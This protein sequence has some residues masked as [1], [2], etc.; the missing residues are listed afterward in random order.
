MQ[1][2]SHFVGPRERPALVTLIQLPPLP[3]VGDTSVKCSMQSRVYA[4]EVFGRGMI[5]AD[6]AEAERWRER[7]QVRMAQTTTRRFPTVA[8]ARRWL[9]EEL[10]V[11]VVSSWHVAAGGAA[12]AGF[13]GGAMDE[14]EE[15]EELIIGP[16]A[17]NEEAAPSRIPGTR[18]RLSR[19]P[20]EIAALEAEQAGS[21]SGRAASSYSTPGHRLALVTCPDAAPV[22][23]VTVDLREGRLVASEAG[24]GPEASGGEPEMLA[25][26]TTEARPSLLGLRHDPLALETAEL[27]LTR[28]SRFPDFGFELVLP[29]NVLYA[30][31]KNLRVRPTL[32]QVTSV[33]GRQAAMLFEA[34]NS[35]LGSIA[36]ALRVT[37]LD[38]SVCLKQRVA[39]WRGRG[40][41]DAKGKAVTDFGVLDSLESLVRERG[42]TVRVTDVQHAARMARQQVIGGAGSGAGSGS[43]NT[44]A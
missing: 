14:E 30:S 32:Q 17:D 43:E 29:G 11:P 20:F 22:T 34:L 7:F 24:A 26:T 35:D 3:C 18:S 9:E 19:T 40:G 33:R 15:E 27:R 1:V 25:A 12:A 16:S 38:M 41:R 23:S 37:S 13:D 44:P 10:R 5:F 8:E 31:A 21:P 28:D 2:A 36:V 42:L 6:W 39:T 4:V